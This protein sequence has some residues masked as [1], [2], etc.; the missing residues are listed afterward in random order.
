[1]KASEKWDLVMLNSRPLNDFPV[2]NSKK[3]NRIFSK[4]SLSR[5][6]SEFQ[7]IENEVFSMKK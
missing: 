5:I 3:N 1:M 2:S 6:F 4:Q 7:G